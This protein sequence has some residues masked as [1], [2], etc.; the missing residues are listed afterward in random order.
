MFIG[1]WTGIQTFY[2]GSSQASRHKDEV[3]AAQAGK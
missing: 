3:I 2:F 1:G